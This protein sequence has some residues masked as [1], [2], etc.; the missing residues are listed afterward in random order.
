MSI[1]VDPLFVTRSRARGKRSITDI[2]RK[3]IVRRC[4]VQMPQTLNHGVLFRHRPAPTRDFG[5][6]NIDNNGTASWGGGSYDFPGCSL[7]SRIR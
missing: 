2:K 5:G 3:N 1:S 7:I 6:L 4:T